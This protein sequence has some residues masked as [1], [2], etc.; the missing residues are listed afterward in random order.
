VLL[1]LKMGLVP[2]ST[3][4]SPLFPV[5]L[6][7]KFP[8]VGWCW[9]RSRDRTACRPKG[10]CVCTWPFDGIIGG[11]RER[12]KIERIILGTVVLCMV[13]YG[14]LKCEGTVRRKSHD[15]CFHAFLM[16]ARVTTF[17]AHCTIETRTHDSHTWNRLLGRG[18]KSWFRLCLWW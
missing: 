17:V 18:H 16:E 4:L 13:V 1:I 11:W 15:P 14:N 12:M 8:V 3:V 6:H 10:L 2:A 9:S 5:P 7:R